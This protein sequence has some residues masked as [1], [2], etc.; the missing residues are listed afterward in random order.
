LKA[1]KINSAFFQHDE[2][3]GVV[4]DAETRLSAKAILVVRVRIICRGAKKGAAHVVAS[5]V[6]SIHIQF[7]QFFHF[8]DGTSETA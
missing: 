3:V 7:I 6:Q 4:T 2:S 1:T 5:D 8:L